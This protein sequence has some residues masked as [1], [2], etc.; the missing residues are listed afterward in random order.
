LKG[1][2]P[3]AN[4]SFDADAFL[5]DWKDI[6]LLADVNNTG[7]NINGGKARSEG[8]EADVTWT[9]IQ[10]LT[11]SLNGAYTDAYLS[12]SVPANVAI[13]VDGMKDDPLPWSPKWS[14]TLNGDYEFA[15]LGKW[16]PYIGASWHYI[17]E[18]QTDF[19]GE[20]YQAAYGIAHNQYTA[21]AYSTID[22]RAGVSFDNWSVELY[23]KNLNDAKGVASFAPYGTSAASAYVS[24]AGPV[25]AANVSLIEPRIVGIVLRGKI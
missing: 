21:S 23:G 9:P 13:F 1:D 4:L 24:P 5:I 20:L 15:A 11:L 6:Q 14:G 12:Q 18:R 25:S 19:I 3:S 22:L 7:V 10:Q 8:V 17:G 2:L 16:T